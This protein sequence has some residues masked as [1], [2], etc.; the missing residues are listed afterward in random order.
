[1]GVE[2]IQNLLKLELIK[3]LLQLSNLINFILYNIENEISF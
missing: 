3:L 1:L 2:I